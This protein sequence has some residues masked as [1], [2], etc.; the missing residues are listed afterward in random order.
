MI[1]FS[2]CGRPDR[3]HYGPCPSVCPHGLISRKLKGAAKPKLVQTSPWH[4]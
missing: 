4:E 1:K 3:P 2:L